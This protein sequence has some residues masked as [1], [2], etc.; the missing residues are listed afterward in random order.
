MLFVRKVAVLEGVSTAKMVFEEKVGVRGL[1][2]G[3][4]CPLGPC[5]LGYFSGT[6]KGDGCLNCTRAA[7]SVLQGD[8]TKMTSKSKHTNMGTGVDVNPTSRATSCRGCTAGKTSPAGSNEIAS[9]IDPLPTYPVNSYWPLG[10]QA[11]ICNEGPDWDFHSLC[12]KKLH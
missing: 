10:S 11:C 8:A 2:L 7:Q 3:I 5:P 4:Y 12:G 6:G 1:G 9:C